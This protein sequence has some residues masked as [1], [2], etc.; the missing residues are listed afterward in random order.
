MRPVKY[1][2]AVCKALAQ[3]AARVVDEPKRVET[4]PKH[5]NTTSN[6]H[7]LHIDAIVKLFSIESALFH[8]KDDIKLHCKPKKRAGAA[9]PDSSRL[10]GTAIHSFL[11]HKMIHQSCFCRGALIRGHGLKW[12][13]SRRRCERTSHRTA[14][15][16]TKEAQT[17][18]TL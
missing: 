3:E 18:C 1:T 9:V 8:V 10:T 2:L 12:V 7:L 14:L 5:R 11:E 6:K 4:L 13:K 15:Q 16:C 17:Q